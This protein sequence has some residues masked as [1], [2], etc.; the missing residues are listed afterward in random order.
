MNK[1]KKKGKY[2]GGE[3]CSSVGPNLQ[4][5][6]IKCSAGINGVMLSTS[7]EKKAE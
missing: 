6:G 1:R 5:M 2:F 7:S 4:L 3:T